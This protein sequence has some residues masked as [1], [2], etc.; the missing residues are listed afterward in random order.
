M[1]SPVSLCCGLVQSLGYPLRR[2]H[3]HGSVQA[4]HRNWLSDFVTRRR[5]RFLLCAGGEGG[6]ESDGEADKE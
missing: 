4:R 1:C 2:R 6:V 3:V 5:E